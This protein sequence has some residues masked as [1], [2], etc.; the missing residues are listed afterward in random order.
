MN[1]YK[2][3]WDCQ[4]SA[5]EYRVIKEGLCKENAELMA[6]ALNNETR[7]HQGKYLVI[8]EASKRSWGNISESV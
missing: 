4:N 8:K 1:D 2:V 7:G 3:V 6:N 5:F